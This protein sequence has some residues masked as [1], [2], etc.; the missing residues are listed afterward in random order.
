MACASVHGP[1]I[2]YA[3]LPC[4]YQGSTS[5]GSR[6]RAPSGIHFLSCHFLKFVKAVTTSGRSQ[7]SSPVSSLSC[8]SGTGR[9]FQQVLVKPHDVPAVL[10]GRG[11]GC[12]SGGQQLFVG[13]LQLGVALRFARNARLL[14]GGL[15]VPAADPKRD[16]GHP[17]LHALESHSLDRRRVDL[18]VPTELLVVRREVHGLLRLD[19]RR[20]NLPAPDPPNV[21]PL[22][23]KQLGAQFVGINR[24]T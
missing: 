16:V 17:A 9:G 15:V 13:L 21:R 8:S 2:V 19:E 18:G 23:T 20:S 14:E 7:V 3:V 12:G 22:A 11:Q 10:A 6:P 4:T 24:R 1:V 5:A